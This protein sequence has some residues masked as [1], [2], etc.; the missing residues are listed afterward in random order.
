MAEARISIEARKLATSVNR[1][2]TFRQTCEPRP[3]KKKPLTNTGRLIH[4]CCDLL[5]HLDLK[6]T[7]GYQLLQLRVL[8]LELPRALHIYL[9]CP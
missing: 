1:P 9:S 3:Q 8:L 6:I 7:F 5:H 2:D 4:F